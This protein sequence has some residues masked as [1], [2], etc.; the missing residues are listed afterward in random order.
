[1]MGLSKWLHWTA[2]YIKYILF[3]FL[4]CCIITI[5][6]C[7]KFS[8]DV[9]VVNKS[10]PT[11]FL[12]WLIIYSSSTICFCFFIST[13]FSKGI[14]SLITTALSHLSIYIN[15]L[16]LQRGLHLIDPGTILNSICNCTISKKIK[17]CPIVVTNLNTSH[18]NESNKIQN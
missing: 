3:L 7:I 1:M 5:L 13:L 2:W 10:D 11:V 16:E 8:E 17:D 18:K 15:K 12:F 9:A 14:F 6:L 4:S